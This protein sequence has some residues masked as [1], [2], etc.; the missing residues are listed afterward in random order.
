MQTNDGISI[1]Q[2]FLLHLNY[3][4]IILPFGTHFA[5]DVG[6]IQHHHMPQSTPFGKKIINKSFNAS[7]SCKKIAK[8]Q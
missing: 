8:I 3:V 1:V 4:P 6:K 7:K 2:Y 5:K